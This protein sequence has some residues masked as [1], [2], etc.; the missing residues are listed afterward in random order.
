VEACLERGEL[1]ALA[2]T[3]V[4]DAQARRRLRDADNAGSTSTKFDLVANLCH[5]APPDTQTGTG[6]A[7]GASGRS[8]AGVAAAARAVGVGAAAPEP[9][10]VAAA[11]AEGSRL[12]GGSGVAPVAGV[13]AHAVRLAAAASD[14]LACGSYRVHVRHEGTAQWFELSDLHG[15]CAA[16]TRWRA[17]GH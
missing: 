16:R 1:V 2:S 5:D 14:P 11:E 8:G 7:S 4:A 15:A 13:A 3:A 6:T 17:G 12:V 10:S 9:R